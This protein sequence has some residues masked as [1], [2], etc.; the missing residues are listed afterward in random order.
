MT[1]QSISADN[2]NIF[3]NSKMFLYISY[4]KGE[5]LQEMAIENLFQQSTLVFFLSSRFTSKTCTGQQ[6]QYVVYLYCFACD[7]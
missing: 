1:T 5:S 3:P 2:V 6:R 4:K 7:F